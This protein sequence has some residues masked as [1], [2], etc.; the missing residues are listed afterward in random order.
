MLISHLKQIHWNKPPKLISLFSGCGGM[1][2]PFHQAGFEV[3]WGIDS[4]LYA[5]QTFKRNIA[6]VIENNQ[7]E[8]INIAEVPEAYLITEIINN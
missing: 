4:N 5:C 1:D 2:L 7:I 3:I 6:D 8:N